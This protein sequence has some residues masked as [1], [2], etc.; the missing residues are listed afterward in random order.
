M[1]LRSL[2]IDG[3]E[4]LIGVE[5]DKPAR[6]WRRVPQPLTGLRE[7]VEQILRQV[8]D[9]P[10]AVTTRPIE[11]EADSS[12]GY[13]VVSVSPSPVAPHMVDGSERST[14]RC[15]WL[16]PVRGLPRPCASRE[17][18]G[19]RHRGRSSGNCF[20]DCRGN[21]GGIFVLPEA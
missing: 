4:L 18:G 7:R 17:P 6:T 3:G 5:E 16:A 21:H 19:R 10:L 14:A 11:S 15:P 13:L 20:S 8:I 1:P 12:V 2:A 9:P